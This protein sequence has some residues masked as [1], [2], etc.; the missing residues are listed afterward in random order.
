[1]KK[2]KIGLTGLGS[3]RINLVLWLLIPV[4][5]GRGLRSNSCGTVPGNY[6]LTVAEKGK[7]CAG[8]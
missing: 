8:S 6:N 7:W 5:D 2:S 1:M 3:L 4:G